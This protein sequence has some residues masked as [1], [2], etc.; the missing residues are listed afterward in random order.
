MQ[1]A[2]IPLPPAG[3]GAIASRKSAGLHAILG[4]ARLFAVQFRDCMLRFTGHLPTN[5][6]RTSIYRWAF[7]VHI[8]Q[9]ARIDGGCIMWGPGRISLGARSVINRGVVLD[10]RFPLT[11][12]NDA[13][14]S[15]R[16][17]ILTLEH[18]LSH[19][20]FRSVG[21]PVIIGDHVFIGTGAIVLPGV[22]IGEG[23]AVAAGAVVAR[24]VAPHTIV[25]G[26]PAK[27]IGSRPKDLAY[28]L[29]KS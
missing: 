23:A 8:A 20:E 27:Q 21:A 29:C 28:N 15:I 1:Q 25:G 7:G 5:A 9:G 17:V 3:F 10:G 6:L 14:I 13:S 26:V 11:I 24:D 12:G 4:G 22:T 19:P 2:K 16:A 18:D